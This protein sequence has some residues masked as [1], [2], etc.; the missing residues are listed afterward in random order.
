MTDA[1]NAETFDLADMFAGIT[2]PKT[3][4]PV[5][6]NPGLGY[7]IHKLSEEAKEAV[8]LK[9]EDKA[10]ELT[11]RRDELVEKSEGF[12]Y[13]FTLQGHSKGERD[14]ITG[15]VKEKFPPE[16]DFLGREKFT[17]EADRLYVNLTWALHIAQIKA[18]NGKVNV[19][20]GAE[21]IELLRSNLPDG[22]QKKIEAGIQELTTGAKAGFET[23]AQEHDFLSGASVE[24]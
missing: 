1:L 9:D 20:P 15:K 12:R 22:E 16:T 21:A 2:Y 18:P 19:A 13:E 3:V 6:T 11:Q 17:D 10:R 24:A 5:Y 14:A 8:L 23:L 7:D 4:V